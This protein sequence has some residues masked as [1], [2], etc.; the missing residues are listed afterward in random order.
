MLCYPQEGSGGPADGFRVAQAQ[1]L[2]IRV[3]REEL[4]QQQQRCKILEDAMQEQIQ[5]SEMGK[6]TEEL[7]M[8]GVGHSS[9]LYTF[10]SL[11][12][13]SLSCI[14]AG[15]FFSS[16]SPSPTIL[17]LWVSI[18][19]CWCQLTELSCVLVSLEMI[20]C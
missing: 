7:L 20:L 15:Y 11:L 4:E 10:I 16:I 6:R 2:E 8:C 14:G 17:S 12:D 1:T 3:L 5:K 9:F 13:H 19:L 18:L